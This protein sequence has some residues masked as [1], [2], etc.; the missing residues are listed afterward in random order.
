MKRAL[1]LL[2]IALVYSWAPFAQAQETTKQTRP[3]I[4]WIFTED[5]NAWMGCYGDKTIKTIED[6]IQRGVEP[7]VD[8]EALSLH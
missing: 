3:N 4:V 7:R 1:V 6:L 2:I 5:M 8:S